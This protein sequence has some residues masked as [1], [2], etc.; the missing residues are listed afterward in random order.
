[1]KRA[2]AAICLA[3]SLVLGSFAGCVD[4]EK[5]LTIAVRIAPSVDGAL[6]V[7]HLADGTEL[8]LDEVGVTVDRVELV[9]CGETGGHAHHAALG[10]LLFPSRA[11]AQHV[12]GSPLVA[13]GPEE[14][15]FGAGAIELSSVLQ[16]APGCYDRVIASLSSLVLRAHAGDRLIEAHSTSRF[17]A[18]A[19]LGPALELGPG[20]A[21]VLVIWL[22]EA[23]PFALLSELPAGGA[24]DGDAVLAGLAAQ[25]HA[26]M[27]LEAQ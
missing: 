7:V 26:R 8:V 6:E 14:V 20:D 9:P 13:L 25:T 27:I 23:V 5:D 4:Y 18:R 3:L 2:P 21:P 1:M 10:T 16:P 12:H 22:A 19:T 17:E 24:L 11:L 15:H